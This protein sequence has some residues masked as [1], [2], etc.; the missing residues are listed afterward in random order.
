MESILQNE[1]NFTWGEQPSTLPLELSSEHPLPMNWNTERSEPTIVHCTLASD[2][3]W[4]FNGLFTEYECDDWRKASLDIG[5]NT[6]REITPIGQC[7]LNHS[8]RTGTPIIW[9][10]STSIRTNKRCI[11]QVP[12]FEVDMQDLLHI[13]NHNR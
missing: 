13:E 1:I 12:R 6:S 7:V 8:A 11:W 4:V 2:G 9:P 3:I 5:Y 10:A